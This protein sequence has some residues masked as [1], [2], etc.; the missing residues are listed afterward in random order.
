MEVWVVWRIDEVA[1]YFCLVWSGRLCAPQRMG[2]RKNEGERGGERI[3]PQHS[4]ETTISA[5]P[6]GH[7]I[8]RIPQCIVG[9]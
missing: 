6:G 9:Y 3:A 4:N 7:K 1:F 5:P 8:G 2:S